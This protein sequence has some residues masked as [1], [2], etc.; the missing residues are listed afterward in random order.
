LEECSKTGIEAEKFKITYR[1]C[2]ILQH[3]FE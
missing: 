2:K 1:I 3:N